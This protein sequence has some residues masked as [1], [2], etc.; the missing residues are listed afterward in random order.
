MKDEPFIQRMLQKG[1]EAGEK[2]K[3]E[4]QNITHRQLNWKPAPDSWSMGQCLDHLVV[5]D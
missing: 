3:I 1:K 4:F 5:A 2:V